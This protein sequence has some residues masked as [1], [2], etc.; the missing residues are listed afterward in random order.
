MCELIHQ[1]ALVL[2]IVSYFSSLPCF[3]VSP[4]LDVCEQDNVIKLLIF[5][6]L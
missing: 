3:C 1:S 4:C 6:Y 5:P 2:M